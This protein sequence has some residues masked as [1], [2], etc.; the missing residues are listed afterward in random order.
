VSSAPPFEN[1]AYLDRETGEVY[2]VSAS[3]D[4]DELPGNVEEDDKYVSI[5]HKNDL[6]L[7]RE[8]VFAFVAAE[9]PDEFE[10]VKRI[11]SKKGAY[12]R[13]KELLESKGRLEAWYG[14]E[15][16][17]TEKA[18]RNWCEEEGIALNG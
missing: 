1:A 15:K 16:Q 7:G 14:F 18:I 10:S 17:A 6:D 11:F 3:G 2:Y 8:L 13:Y 5:P 4:S 12:A 9:I